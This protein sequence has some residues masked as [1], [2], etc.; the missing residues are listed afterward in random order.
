MASVY[1]LHSVKLNRFYIGS[2]DDL[3]FRIEQHLN[4]EFLGG[5]TAKVDD[6]KLFYFKDGLTYIQ[7]R[8]IETHLK[9]MRN[10]T[11]YINLK[12]YPNIMEKLIE[13]YQ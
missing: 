11:Y 2:C 10:K 13:K 4:K 6:W 8:N 3:S 7:A 5:F 9:K 12:K 1:L